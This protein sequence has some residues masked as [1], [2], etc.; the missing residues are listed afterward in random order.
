M[1]LPLRDVLI[2]IIDTQLNQQGFVNPL[3]QVW[4]RLEH[5]EAVAV[6]ELLSNGAPKEALAPYAP[7]VN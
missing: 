2:A 1:S 4:R 5:D 3:G 7:Y 6:R